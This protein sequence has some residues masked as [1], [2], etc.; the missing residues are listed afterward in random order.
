MI[1]DVFSGM[2]SDTKLLTLYL[3]LWKSLS[4]LKVDN[5]TLYYT[6]PYKMLIGVNQLLKLFQVLNTAGQVLVKNL[7]QKL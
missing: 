2:D 3:R 6:S 1:P 5:F 4:S 7:N